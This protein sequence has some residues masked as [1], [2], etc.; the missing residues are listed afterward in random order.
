MYT[1]NSTDPIS[2]K[3]RTDCKSLIFYRRKPGLKTKLLWKY[4]LPFCGSFNL[5]NLFHLNSA[6]QLCKNV[7]SFLSLCSVSNGRSHFLCSPNFFQLWFIGSRIV[8]ASWDNI[9]NRDLKLKSIFY[10][11]NLH[12]LMLVSYHDI[13]T[14]MSAI[15]SQFS[16][17]LF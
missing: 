13:F 3:L 2:R 6:I 8:P 1:F 7:E 10:R 15:K 12:D 16:I 5:F 9:S 17:V 4:Y 11:L 14:D